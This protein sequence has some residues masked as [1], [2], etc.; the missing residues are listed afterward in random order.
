MRR[1]NALATQGL[2]PRSEKPPPALEAN[3]SALSQPVLNQCG[4]GVSRAAQGD[5]PAVVLFSLLI[6]GIDHFSFLCC[7]GYPPPADSGPGIRGRMLRPFQ[8]GRKEALVAGCNVAAFRGFH[9]DEQLE[10]VPGLVENQI[11]MVNPLQRLVQVECLPQEKSGKGCRHHM[12]TTMT[13][14]SNDFK[15]EYSIVWSILVSLRGEQFQALLRCCRATGRAGPR[16]E[17]ID[18]PE[19]GRRN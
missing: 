17:E 1:L 3:P 7:K 4:V 2:L 12:G 8:V 11:G 10:Q 19:S 14:R 6:A 5:N 18:E 15:F 16:R 13:R 9:I